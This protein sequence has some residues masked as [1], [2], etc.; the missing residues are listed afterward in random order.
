M[1]SVVPEER[2]LIINLKT[3]WEVLCNFLQVPIPDVPFPQV[4]EQP[5]SSISK[6]NPQS[7]RYSRLINYTIPFTLLICLGYAVRKRHRIGSMLTGIIMPCKK[8]ML[9]SF[10]GFFESLINRTFYYISNVPLQVGI[11]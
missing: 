4:T 8:C 11:I 10:H 3:E 1:K 2:L 5:A 9:Y 6:S 7:R